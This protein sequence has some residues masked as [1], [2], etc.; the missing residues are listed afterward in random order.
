M[1]FKTERLP[2]AV[3]LHASQSLTL[4]GCEPSGLRK[5]RFIFDD[6]DSK[7]SSCELDFETGRPI[8]AAAIFASQK[9]LRQLMIRELDKHYAEKRGL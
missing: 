6:P 4:I 1:H 3:Y 7:A 2:L 5:I 8:S 9:Y